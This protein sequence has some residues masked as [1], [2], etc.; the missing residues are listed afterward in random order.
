MSMTHKEPRSLSLNDVLEVLASKSVPILAGGTDYF[1]ALGEKVVP[2]QLLD[3]TSVSE[4]RGIIQDR[5]GWRIGATTTWTDIIN[6]ELPAAFDGLK[7]AAKEVGSIQIQNAAT[8]AGNLCNASPA[9]DGVPPLLA[10]NASVELASLTQRRWL[11]LAQFINGPRSTA[12][13]ANELLV[14]I[15][16]PT[17]SEDVRSGF[18]KLGSRK[19]LVISIAMASVTL[20]AD[21]NGHLTEVRIAVGACSAVARRLELLEKALKGQSVHSDVISLITPSLF[22]ELTPI[23]DVRGSGQYRMLAA[24]QIVMRLILSTLNQLPQYQQSKH[25]ADSQ[26]QRS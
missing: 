14:S 19:Y 9:A 21:K 5:Q 26:G 20:A 1:P 7:A 13:A 25:M 6:A 16:I 8:I 10:L 15:H 2:N 12:L 3:I 4:L 17:L 22:D 24:H 18:Y 11:P 23:D